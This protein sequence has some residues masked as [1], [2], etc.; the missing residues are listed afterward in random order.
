MN[1]EEMLNEASNG[2]S[3]RQIRKWYEAQDLESL[4]SLDH[5]IHGYLIRFSH[6][7]AQSQAQGAE[8]QRLTKLFRNHKPNERLEVAA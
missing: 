5:W 2:A 4:R 7:K 6:P 8:F 1:V 3:Y